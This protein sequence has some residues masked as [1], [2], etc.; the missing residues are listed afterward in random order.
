MK[1]QTIIAADVIVM[2]NANMLLII[3]RKFSYLFWKKLNVDLL[4]FY[5]EMTP[6]QVVETSG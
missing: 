5:H 3:S 1:N 4:K 6:A 2:S